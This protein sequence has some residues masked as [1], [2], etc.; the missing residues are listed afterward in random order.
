M[1]GH[2]LSSTK[3]TELSGEVNAETLRASTGSRRQGV[4]QHPYLQTA[5]H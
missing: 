2:Q 4:D 3:I 1:P 5:V